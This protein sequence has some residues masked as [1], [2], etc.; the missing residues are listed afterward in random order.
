MPVVPIAAMRAG[1][2]GQI[3]DIFGDSRLIAILGERGFR[4]GCRLEALEIGDPLLV[5]VDETRLS[6]RTDG[7]VEVLVQVGATA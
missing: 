1:E 5:K 2:Y 7:Q 3:V 4:K 6:L